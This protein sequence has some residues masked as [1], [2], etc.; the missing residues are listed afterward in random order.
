[1]TDHSFPYVMVYSTLATIV[2]LASV[3]ISTARSFQPVLGA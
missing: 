3:W 1:M 2:S